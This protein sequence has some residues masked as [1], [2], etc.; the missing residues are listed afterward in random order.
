MADTRLIII[1]VVNVAIWTGLFLFLL[2]SLM[3][4][5]KT[6]SDRLAAIEERH[7][8]DRP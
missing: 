7:K 3:R 4:S 6:I 1:A 5:N 8:D 2:F